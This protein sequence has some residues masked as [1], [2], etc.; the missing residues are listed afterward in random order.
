MFTGFSLGLI[1]LFY[2]LIALGSVP[3]LRM[4]RTSIALVGAALCVLTGI[5]SEDEALHALDVGT[6]LLLGAMMV[7]NNNL[8]LAGFFDVVASR[9]L[10]LAKTPRQLLALLIAAAGLLSALFLN[11][12]IC[13][14]LTP[15][16]LELTQRLQRDPLPYLIGLATATNVG[17]VATVTGNPQNLLIARAGQLDYLTFAGYLTPVALVGLGICWA[18]VMLSF[19]TEFQGRFA[20]DSAPSAPPRYYPPLLWRTLG[21]VAGLLLAF[22]LGAPIVSAACCAAGAL[23]ISRLRPAKL[24]ELDWGL[25][26]FFAGLFVLTGALEAS[27]W[28]ARLFEQSRP[29]LQEGVLPLSVVT[30]LLS[31]LVSNVPAVLLLR[32]EVAALDDP[33]LG[34]LTLAMASTLAGNFTLLG[35]AANLIVAELA[36]QRGVR[37][38]FWDYLRAGVPITLLTLALGAGWLTWTA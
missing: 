20:P 8:R 32:G 19:P 22:L 15:F 24:L 29:L 25:L 1:A 9:V 31:N 10:V 17:S 14:M 23:L 34:W 3:R 36:A 35:S 11:D 12:T 16:V 28:S 13:V 21:V 38:S 5:L 37:L 18:V 26:A 2:G 6:I 4:N 33:Q 7:I 27:G 30:A